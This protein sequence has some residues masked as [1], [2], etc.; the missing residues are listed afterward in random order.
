MT[1]LRELQ[2]VERVEVFECFGNN[3]EEVVVTY[4]G[5]LQQH[6]QGQTEENHKKTAGYQK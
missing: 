1:S 5:L 3:V 6:L 2:G 4:Y